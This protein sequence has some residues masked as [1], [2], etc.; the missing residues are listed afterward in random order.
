MKWHRG[1]S[2]SGAAEGGMA[3]FDRGGLPASAGLFSERYAG[4]LAPGGLSIYYEAHEDGKGQSN[5]APAAGSCP[6]LR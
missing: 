4:L 5:Y 2:V 6:C 3:A 1:F